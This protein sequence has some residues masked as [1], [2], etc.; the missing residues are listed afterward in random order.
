MLS[1]KQEGGRER[2]G[3]GKREGRKERGEEGGRE[4][5]KKGGKEG[6]REGERKRSSYLVHFLEFVSKSWGKPSVQPQGGTGLSRGAVPC[7]EELNLP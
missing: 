7:P 6:R 2:K 4:R 3:E 5:E 1:Q